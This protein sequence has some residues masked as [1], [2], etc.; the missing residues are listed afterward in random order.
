M[1]GAVVCDKDD[2]VEIVP[3]GSMRPVGSRAAM[4]LQARAGRFHVVP[5]PTNLV[6]LKE[7]DGPDRPC[8]LSGEI[9]SAGALCDVLSFVGHSGYTGEL[10][11]QEVDS[12]RSIFFEQGSVVFAQSSVVRERLGEVLYR[13]GVLTRD[14]VSK[15]GD[16]T[17][18][19]A[20][21]F[22]EAAVKF[23][24]VSREKLFGLM[25]HQTEEI[26]YGMMLCSAAMFYFLQGFDESLL[27]SRHKLS[28]TALLRDGIRRMHEMR[29]FRARI[30]SEAHIPV[31][32][33]LGATS[34]ATPQ[35][36]PVGELDR[37]KVYDAIDGHRSVVEICRAVGASEFEVTRALFHL[38]QTGRVFVKPPRLPPKEIARVYNQAIALILRELDAMDE[39][40]AV[41]AQLAT[42]AAQ[43]SAHKSLLGG[44]LPADDGTFDAESTAK[45]LAAD[46]SPKDAEDRLAA[47]LYEYA[48][49]ALFL[50]RPHLRRIEDLRAGQKRISTRVSAMLEPIAPRQGYSSSRPEPKKG[51]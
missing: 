24:F 44:A 4:R 51:G 49:Y 6:V 38:I 48:S 16:A 29:Y 7:A 34:L 43:S 35:A 21:R 8:L 14:Q 30:P 26:F 15:C 23:G 46:P 28:V 5:S 50:A 1:L 20:M 13:C 47:W 42:F 41:R 25:G 31:K 9:R 22:G 37:L 10:V 2:L 33:Q 12:T 27:S 3:D 19:G 18:T 17:A 40:D 11:V 36:V 39:G 45:R 32:T